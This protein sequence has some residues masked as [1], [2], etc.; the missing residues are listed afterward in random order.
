MISGQKILPLLFLLGLWAAPASAQGMYYGLP[1]MEVSAI[2][3]ARSTGVEASFTF[4]LHAGIAAYKLKETPLKGPDT[5]ARLDL[6]FGLGKNWRYFEAFHFSTGLSFV[7]DP[8]QRRDHRIQGVGL[9]AQ[10]DLT[11][12]AHVLVGVYALTPLAKGQD[13]GTVGLK[14]GVRLPPY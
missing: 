8:D 5:G 2:S 7:T 10:A 13:F 12:G 6:G 9:F 4:L 3:D 1:L 14:V 11:L